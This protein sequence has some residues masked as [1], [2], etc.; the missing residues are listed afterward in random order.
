[1]FLTEKRPSRHGTHHV[2]ILPDSGSG[3]IAIRYSSPR[4]GVEPGHGCARWP[5]L[6]RGSGVVDS[7]RLATGSSA[8]RS[9]LSPKEDGN[10]SYRRSISVYSFQV[11]QQPEK[12]TAGGLNFLACSSRNSLLAN[13]LMPRQNVDAVTDAGLIAARVLSL[14][15]GCD[16]CFP[17]LELQHIG[18][19]TCATKRWPLDQPAIS[20]PELGCGRVRPA[21][22]PVST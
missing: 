8:R 12:Q 11:T 22:T 19:G 10:A 18:T 5:S 7:Q 21:L 4:H 3:I 20:L 9:P 16:D 6:M 13:S 14:G 17:G 1:M 2:V 15:R